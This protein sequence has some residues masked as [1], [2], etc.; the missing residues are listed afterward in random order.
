MNLDSIINKISLSKDK[1]ISLLIGLILIIVISNFN[2]KI[3]TFVSNSHE[4]ILISTLF[5][6]GS[7]TGKPI[8]DFFNCRYLFIITNKNMKGFLKQ[9]TDDEK[10]Y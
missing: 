9:L 10:K 4:Y 7:I 5:L 1:Q 3:M 2:E 8:Y 6:F